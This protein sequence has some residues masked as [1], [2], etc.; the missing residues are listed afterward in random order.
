MPPLLIVP[1]PTPLVPGTLVR[2]YNRFMADVKLDSGETVVAHC[3]NTGRM[4]GITQPGLRVWLSHEPSPTRKL[5]YTWQI[6]EVEGPILVGTNTALP[7][8]IVGS[9]LRERLLPG[10]PWDELQSERRYG[11]NSR[12]DFW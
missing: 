2:R 8:Q 9:I 11:E 12:I 5:A 7:N 4:E 1:F 6:T 3:V 10:F